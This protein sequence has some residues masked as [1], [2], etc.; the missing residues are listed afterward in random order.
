VTVVALLRRSGVKP[1]SHWTDRALLAA[2]ARVL[3]EQLRGHRLV[4]PKTLPRWH[5]RPVAKRWT[6][7]NKP[8]GRHSL[9]R[10]RR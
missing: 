3:P 9:P 7:P 10:P 6:Y 2:L 8:V 4:T 5:R 1:K